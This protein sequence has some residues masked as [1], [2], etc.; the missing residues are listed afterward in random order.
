M[1]LLVHEKLICAHLNTNLQR[2]QFDQLANIIRDKV[3][4]LMISEGKLDS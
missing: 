2:K 1:I 4:I 3:G